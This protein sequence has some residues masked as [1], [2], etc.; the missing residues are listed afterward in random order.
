MTW[1]S[2]K[3]F[4]GVLVFQQ[5][6]DLVSTLYIVNVLGGEEANPI[7]APVLAAPYGW[8]WLALLK[9]T[10]ATVL[11]ILVPAAVKRKSPVLWTFKI[12]CAAYWMLVL[13]HCY[14]LGNVFV[15]T[16]L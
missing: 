4:V 12:L 3:Q 16:M 5:L 8:A 13:W 1:L 7:L 9:V 10:A 6:F 15:A 14:I 11:A 2:T